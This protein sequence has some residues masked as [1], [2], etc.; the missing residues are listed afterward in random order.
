M[1]HW[2]QLATRNWRTKPART[3]LTSGAV[4]LGVG[5]VVWVTCCYES[6]R[7]SVTDAVLEWIGRSHLMIE[8]V[9][10]VWAVFDEDIEAIAKN[11]PGVAATTVRTREYIE[12]GTDR[13]AGAPQDSQLRTQDFA[14][15]EISGINP[16]KE[17]AFRTYKLSAGRFLAATDDK[18]ILMEKLLADEMNVGVGDDVLLRD[19]EPPGPATAFRVVGIVDRRRASVNQAPM[20]WGR[21][22]D[23]QSLCSLPKKVKAVDIM[24]ANPSVV[25]I[26]E[27]GTRL[28][29]LLDERAEKSGSSSSDSKSLEVNTTEAQLQKL[30]AAQG[31][32][33]FIMTLLACVV[34]MTALFIIL[35]SMSMG[36]TERVA[37][38]GLLRCIGV[39]RLQIVGF[40]LAQTMPIGVVG[41]LIGVPLGLVLQWLTMQA[42]PDYVG[43]MAVSAWGLSLAILGGL[44]T[45]LLGA[46]L[47]AA[48]AFWISPVEAVRSAGTLRAARWLAFSLI[49]GIALLAGHEWLSRSIASGQSTT[50]D[51]RA[52]AS[53]LLLYGGFVLIAPMVIVLTGRIA[54]WAAALL[55]RLNSR[56]LG[57]ETH[58]APFR[59]A[60]IAG[61]L[62][63][64]LSLIVGLVV[65][66]DSVKQGWQ[67][68][69]EFPD[70]MLYSYDALPLDLARSVTKTPGIAQVTVC[71]DFAFSLSKPSIFRPFTVLDQ[72][73]RFLAIDIDTGFDIVKLAFLEGNERDARQRLRAGGH[74]LVTRE[75]A[76]ARKVKLGDKVRLW[77]DKKEASFIVAGVVASPGLD[78]AMSFFNATTYFQ[79]YA[80]GAVFGTLDDANRLFGRNYGKLF[81]M[82]F[83]FPN[84]DNSRLAQGET[85]P[86]ALAPKDQAATTKRVSETGRPTFALGSGP[87]PGDG[88]EEQV[89]NVMLKKLGWPDKA[90]VTA[91]ELK[92]EIDRNIDRVTLLLSAIPIVGLLVSALGL[93]NLMAANVASRS[94]EIAV[95]RSIGLTRGQL[96]RMVLGESVVL[97]LI[98]SGLGL[99][100]GLALGR[101]SNVM[102]QAL[103][104]FAPPMSVPWTMVLGGAAA[105]IAL[106]VLAALIPARNAGRT[107]I[108]QVLSGG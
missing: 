67:F 55:L 95:L 1:R 80:V 64:G 50:Y 45:T 82:N 19:F 102:T 35:A 21:L 96:T 103:S 24:L 11:L 14:R 89:A 74:I 32:L 39:T 77:V 75:F 66:G 63:V 52:I 33:Q 51:A 12:I 65:W 57:T 83:D 25:S 108:V 8:P 93:A 38:L 27:A 41:T 79:T 78:I 87:V 17:L 7:R 20:V 42:A 37:E 97:G 86:I 23:V 94:R 18:S 53:L 6:V 3:V 9:E 84:G 28:R 4:A 106:C 15:I 30:S 16:D 76:K 48:S 31:L 26:Q 71:D 60:A 99:A 44:G 88:P 34:L 91:R 69:K 47:P 2:L 13:R 104:G 5:V 85:R 10:G 72:F 90:F 54:S 101:A 105:A 43:Q 29:T 73:S 62:M 59:S 81:L 61:G 49:A 40:I 58:D 22:V 46:A 68:P 70:A 36:V 92:R 107:N 56:L 100:L 98:G